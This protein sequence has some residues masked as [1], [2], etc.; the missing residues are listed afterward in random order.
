LLN[1]LA[2]LGLKKW[3][4]VLEFEKLAGIIFDVQALAG[5]LAKFLKILVFH[6]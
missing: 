2:K 4:L 6:S 3:G 5:D 1:K